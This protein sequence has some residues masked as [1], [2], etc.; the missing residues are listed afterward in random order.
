MDS[1]KVTVVQTG[2]V[3][4]VEL[5]EGMTAKQALAAADLLPENMDEDGLQVRLNGAVITDL[6]I[7]LTAGDQLLVVGDIAGGL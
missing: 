4:E 1:G 6:D 7:V 3:N 5:T 2:A